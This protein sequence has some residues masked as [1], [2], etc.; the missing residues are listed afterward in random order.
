MEKCIVAPII[1]VRSD[2]RPFSFQR[3]RG[4]NTDFPLRARATPP[5]R[6]RDERNVSHL[7]RRRVAI[8]GRFFIAAGIDNCVYVHVTG[9][10]RRE[11]GPIAGQDID[12]AAGKIAR[13]D[14]L[15]ECERG[16]GFVVDGSTTAQLPLKI[17][18]ATSETNGSN[19]GSSGQIIT[20]TPVGSGMVK[21][22]C[23]LETGLTVPNIWQN[24]SV[25]PA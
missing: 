11:F 15:G 25:Q 6:A 1:L 8:R 21:L 9:K 13:G 14:D 4:S 17:T 24:L 7:I 19:G 10:V 2:A 18:G 16:S 12:H 20:T 23:E 3:Y 22:K 5:P